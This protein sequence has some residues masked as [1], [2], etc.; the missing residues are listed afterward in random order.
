MRTLAIALMLASS[1][2]AAAQDTAPQP[3]TEVEEQIVVIGERMH[4]WN[5]GL[6]KVDGKLTCRTKKSSGDEMVDAIRCGAML[7]CMGELAPQID[8]VMASDIARKEKQAQVQAIAEGAVPCMDAYHKT[9]VMRL[10]QSR[11]GKL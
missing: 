11:A 7:T 5:G 6:A 3:Q 9:A 10:A 8:E 1:G 2:A 4:T